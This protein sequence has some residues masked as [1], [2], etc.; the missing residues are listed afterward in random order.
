VHTYPARLHPALV[1]HLMTALLAARA[2]APNPPEH[3]PGTI[4]DPFCG[5]GT[6][7]VEAR[8]A[9][10][11][12][13]GVDANP[14]AV[15]LAHAKTWTAPG[16]RRAA[17]RRIG[18]DLAAAAWNEG[19][20]AR[21]A[22]YQPAPL[23]APAGGDPAARSRA[24]E[25]WFAPHVRREL[26]FLATGIDDVRAEDPEL[27]DVLTVVLSSILYKVSRRASDTDPSRVERSVGRGA[28]AR[29]FGERVEL[30]C[31]GLDALAR[32][33]DAPMPSVHRGDARSLDKAGVAPASIDAVITSPPYAG[34]YDFAEQHQ[35]RL[36][37]LSLPSSRFREA[38]L[39]AR[40]QFV[41]EGEERRRARRRYKR[42]IAAALTEMAR[43]LVPGG[44]AAVILGD[45]VAG[46]RAMKADEVIREALDENLVLHAW[47]SQER[48]KLGSLESEAF[49][50]EPKR[51]HIFLLTR[52]A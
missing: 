50:D 43:V 29:L 14:L 23:R 12:A 7:L 27:A 18:R 24:L 49:G 32:A 20:A 38:E 26:E 3:A 35:L 46:D 47:A 42:A 25:G 33:S 30:L 45:S 39:G 37:F 51:E 44:F 36:D 52:R 17:L 15:L 10:A 13:V 9:G 8:R 19:K 34:T 28:A 11:H 2:Q 48:P 31:K 22:D 41:G 40:Q 4:L 21:R 5:A 6:V 1:R 16:P